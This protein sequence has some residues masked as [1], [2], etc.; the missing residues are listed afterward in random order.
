[1][2]NPQVSKSVCILTVLSDEALKM[3]VQPSHRLKLPLPQADRDQWCLRLDAAI[4]G[5]NRLVASFQE[6]HRGIKVDWRASQIV[7]GKE[8]AGP[9][10]FELRDKLRE[11]VKADRETVLSIACMLIVDEREREKQGAKPT[12]CAAG[13]ATADQLLASGSAHVSTPSPVGPAL[14]E[15]PEVAAIRHERESGT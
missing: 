10:L 13:T 4:I 2:L 14:R 9:E 11:R 15:T 5:H 6:M 3:M 7:D 12:T 8:V 1:M